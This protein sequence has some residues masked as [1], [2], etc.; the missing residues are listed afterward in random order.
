M[1]HHRR[2]ADRRRG[3]ARRRGTLCQSDRSARR[4]ALLQYNSENYDTV[5]IQTYSGDGL[6]W[7]SAG[8]AQQYT[9]AS[10]LTNTANGPLLT[11]H[12]DNSDSSNLSDVLDMEAICFSA[13]SAAATASTIYPTTALSRGRLRLRPDGLHRPVALPRK[14]LLLPQRRRWRGL[15]VLTRRFLI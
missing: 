12:R 14:H 6:L 9:Y 4:Y 11:A 3:D 10:Y 5:A 2:A 13:A 15:P 7:S 1:T 8:E